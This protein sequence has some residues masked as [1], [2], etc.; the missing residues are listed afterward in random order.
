MDER[1]RLRTSRSDAEISLSTGE[2]LA[3]LAARAKSADVAGRREYSARDVYNLCVHGDA[4]PTSFEVCGT[5]GFYAAVPWRSAEQAM[6]RFPV[7][8]DH[9]A[10]SGGLRLFVRNSD[11]ACLNVKSIVDIR[12]EY[13][14]ELEKP[15]FGSKLPGNPKVCKNQA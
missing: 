11:N 7:D 13:D 1:I 5:D 14:D 4:E 15:V 8:A 9:A 10:T 12:F 6:F 3:D 2:L